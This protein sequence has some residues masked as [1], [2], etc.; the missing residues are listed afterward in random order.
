MHSTLLARALGLDMLLH[1]GV[2][3]WCAIL[4]FNHSSN[5]MLQVE[6]LS[7]RRLPSRTALASAQRSNSCTLLTL[8][9]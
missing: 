2:D 3:N 4:Q 9:S 8:H 1:F 6:G 7:C 5:A